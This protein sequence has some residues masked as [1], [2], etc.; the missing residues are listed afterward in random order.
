[1]GRDNRTISRLIELLCVLISQ[2][3][4]GSMC[5]TSRRPPS[6]ASRSPLR[7][8]L[9]SP[10]L[11]ATMTVIS[12]RC[13]VTGPWTKTRRRGFSIV[14]STHQ[15]RSLFVGFRL[16]W[17]RRQVQRQ[18]DAQL[19]PDEPLYRSAE[20]GHVTAAGISP[21][22][23]EL[24]QCSF[25]RAQY[26]KPEDVLKDSRP[27]H[28]AIVEVTCARLPKDPVPRGDGAA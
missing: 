26:S 13:S 14:T 15:F 20:P 28:T 16:S 3:R 9:E 11:N 23:V 8:D 1:M 17:A 24:P 4:W 19:P 18:A 12:W 10:C 25:N 5:H 21:A 27:L 6:V 2:R 7:T 22:A